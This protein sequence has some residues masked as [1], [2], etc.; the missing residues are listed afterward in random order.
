MT[1]FQLALFICTTINP[2]GLNDRYSKD[3]VW[4][5]QSLYLSEGKCDVE[6]SQQHGKPVHR[7]SRII[8]STVNIENHKCSS[9]Y[10]SE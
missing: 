5:N 10:V 3:C 7:F 4:E 8:G 9:V 6:G 2:T 1:I